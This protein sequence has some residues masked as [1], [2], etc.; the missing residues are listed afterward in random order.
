M[1]EDQTTE[2]STDLESSI[3][4]ATEAVT[5]QSK[6][7]DEL[8]D[9]GDDAQPLG[10]GNLMGVPV[11]VTVQV[12]R[13]RIS[14]AELVQLKPG[15]VMT[16][17]REAHEPADILVNGRVVA[18]GEVVTVGSHYGVRITDVHSTEEG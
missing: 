4:Q 12:G 7:L 5:V 11:R 2:N 3:E 16:L 18:C 15:S 14:I 8:I 1:S 10:I 13:A 6:E 9:V 17:D